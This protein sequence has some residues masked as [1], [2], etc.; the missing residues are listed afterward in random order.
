MDTETI[1][2]AGEILQ[3]EK[4]RLLTGIATSIVAEKSANRK[5]MEQSHIERMRETHRQVTVI[6]DLCGDFDELLK[7][8]G[9]KPRE[10]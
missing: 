1:K 6:N 5:I 2:S 4:Q 8:P 7:P 10:K 3:E 9:R